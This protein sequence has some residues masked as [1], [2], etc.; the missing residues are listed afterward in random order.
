MFDRL[1]APFDEFQNNKLAIVTFNYDRSLEQYFFDRFKHTHYT[2][3]KKNKEE[4]IK[5]LNQLEILH[6]YGS[7]GHLPWQIDD[8]KNPIP[9]VSY[10][11]TDE[12]D[13]IIS[14]AKNIEIMSE[15]SSGVS[16]GLK[17]FQDLMKD[18]QA[19]YFLGFGYHEVNIKRL[20]IEI[21]KRPRKIMGTAYRLSYQRMKEIERLNIRVLRTPEGLFRKP[22]YDFLHDCVDFN[23]TGYP[24]Q[25]A[26]RE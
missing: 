18:C 15:T 10:G 17:K 23:E 1:D 12:Q 8:S 2:H 24:P 3:T 25:W 7:L 4:L 9:Q 26:Y 11:G 14:A 19:L 20:G 21:L 6:V 13:T 22:I 5:K 16:A